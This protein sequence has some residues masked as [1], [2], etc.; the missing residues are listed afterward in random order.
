LPGCGKTVMSVFLQDRLIDRGC[1]IIQFFC[2]NDEPSKRRPSFIISTL[3]S[4]LLDHPELVAYQ[5]RIAALI[6]IEYNKNDNITKV[7]IDA[8]CALLESV[9]SNLPLVIIIIDALDEC[10]AESLSRGFLIE[11]LIQL[12]NT[13]IGTKVILTSRQEE[14]F[15]E[16]FERFTNLEMS[17]DDV[18]NDIEAVIRKSIESIPKLQSLKDKVI[19]ALA[20]GA[21]GMFLWAEL[22]LATLKKAR[23]RNA[24]EKMLANLPVG[25]REIY[26]HILISIGRKLSED[27]LRFR[28]EI[29]GW[30][31]TV[32]R[33][34]TLAELSIALAIEPGTTSLDDGEIILKLENDIRDLCGPMLR[35]SGDCTVQVVHM[36]VRDMLHRPTQPASRPTQLSQADQKYLVGFTIEIEHARLASVC[37]T[38]LAFEVF[39]ER[40]IIDQAL[41]SHH[42]LPLFAKE[43]LMLE[44]ATSNWIYHISASADAGTELL[45]RIL[46]FLQSDN[47]YIWIQLMSTF[48]RRSYAN[49]SIH[50]LQRTKMLNWAGSISKQESSES[51]EVLNTYLFRAIERGV[52]LSQA[53]LG[54]NHVQ[55]LLALQRLAYLYDHEDRLEES[56]QIHQKVIDATTGATDPETRKILLDSCIELAYIYRVKADY[57]RAVDLLELV[58][59]GPD[60]SK[61]TYDCTGAEAIAD[62]G[63]VY[64]L[65]GDLDRAREIG[66]KGVEGLTVT[67]GPTDILTIRYV[68]QLCRT[69]FECGLYAEAQ[70]LLE[71]TLKT[72]DEAIGAEE[73]TTLHGRD[74]LGNI[75][76][77]KGELDTAETLL[78]G[79]LRLMRQQWGE[80]GRST[81]LLKTHVADVLTDKGER[82][83]AS[84]LY[85][86][87]TET[88]E[89]F[90]GVEHPQTRAVAI[91]LARCYGELALLDSAE[92]V[93][94]K[95]RI[96]L[97]DVKDAGL[98]KRVVASKLNEST[99]ATEKSIGE[100]VVEEEWVRVADVRLPPSEKLR[101]EVSPHVEEVH[102]QNEK[103][104]DVSK[105][106]V[107]VHNAFEALPGL[108]VF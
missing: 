50:I 10:D 72:A 86:G 93:M 53:S 8:L 91:K 94:V 104:R 84:V 55:T 4:Q 9:L 102:V 62:L 46:Q 57:D 106:D 23:N 22:M 28:R 59:G 66:E 69:Y 51:T 5:D 7:S 16:T 107:G 58:L 44:Y 52:Q 79:V 17:K 29:F 18:S 96:S 68:I 81:A 108:A 85:A 65:K 14:P 38:Y 20:A 67:M 56:R 48:N 35:I 39:R 90:Y 25:L 87:A 71:D 24:V 78:R 13:V 101:G 36:S 42:E 77:A 15:V 61:W 43:H 83:E 3:L 27:E 32:V 89:A 19:S 30:V 105:V 76:H 75:L 103:K 37:I 99:T 74:L 95:Y 6:T 97:D 47:A 92:S 60:P 11:R 100:V 49:F 45:N 70:T 1:P 98:V 80:G 26:E 63:V 41:R 2:K 64:R 73:S 34:M 88:Y 21:D 31:I 82:V 54:E 40:E 12:S 33:P